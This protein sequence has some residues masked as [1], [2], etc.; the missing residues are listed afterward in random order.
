MIKEFSFFDKIY[1]INLYTRKDR[2]SSSKKIFKK[3]NIP[4]T[5]YQTHKHPT[6]GLQGCFESHI[7]VIKKAYDEGA[8]NVLIFE[9]DL[10]SNFSLKKLQQSI[11]FMKDKYWDIFYLGAVP[12]IR[13]KGTTKVSS[14]PGIYKLDGICTH[15]YAVNYRAMKKLKEVEYTGIPYDFFLRDN[16]KCY[17]IYPSLFYQGGYSSDISEGIDVHTILSPNIVRMWFKIME[18]YSYHIGIS[19]PRLKIV[20]VFIII[21]YL[22]RINTQVHF[23]IFILILLMMLLNLKE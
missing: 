18:T 17:A 20:A 15:A 11:K 6:S 5:Y 8:K 10:R 14:F 19:M 13:Y 2:Y 16:F 9:D 22:L 4:V 21:W 12:D 7:N 23:I 3:H 1:C